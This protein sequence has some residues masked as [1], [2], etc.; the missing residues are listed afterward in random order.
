MIKTSANTGQLKFHIPV[1]LQIVNGSSFAAT[2]KVGEQVLIMTV[3]VLA[4]LGDYRNELRV[5]LNFS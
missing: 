5:T 4:A 3:V 1:Q 2:A